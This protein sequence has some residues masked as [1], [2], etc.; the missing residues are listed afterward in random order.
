MA[1][2]AIA[3]RGGVFLPLDL[4]RN[5]DAISAVGIRRVVDLVDQFLDAR[6]ERASPAI[7]AQS[8]ARNAAP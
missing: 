1:V 7:V 4:T 2:D 6:N 3:K 5:V 8:I